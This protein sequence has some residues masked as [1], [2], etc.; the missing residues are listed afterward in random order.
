MCSERYERR[1]DCI[2]A[3]RNK[4]SSNASWEEMGDNSQ[5]RRKICKR[6]LFSLQTEKIKNGQQILTMAFNKK[7][8]IRKSWKG[9]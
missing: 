4:G 6:K 3:T 9:K 2:Q 7:E 1:P 8:V 5:N